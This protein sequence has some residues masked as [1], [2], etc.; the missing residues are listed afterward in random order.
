[1]IRGTNALR[2][3]RLGRSMPCIPLAVDGAATGRRR[4]GEDP[5]PSPC[6]A[7]CG[8]LVFSHGTWWLEVGC[9]TARLLMWRR[10]RRSSWC[11]L[12]R[13]PSPRSTRPD[14]AERRAVRKF[15]LMT[16]MRATSRTAGQHRQRSREGRGGFGSADGRG[17]MTPCRCACAA[18]STHPAGRG[19]PLD[20]S[21][22][23]GGAGLPQRIVPVSAGAP[24]AA[25]AGDPSCTRPPA[26][27]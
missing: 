4:E 2:P 27:R 1:M 23:K 6:C 8:R 24:T 15:T 10:C 11:A 14:G 18:E 26:T 5:G 22:P 25:A 16:A 9:A 3:S 17:W 12:R 13:E 20:D 21:Q 19:E 7:R